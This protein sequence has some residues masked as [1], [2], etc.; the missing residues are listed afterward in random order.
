MQGANGANRSKK[1]DSGLATDPRAFTTA[2]R[3]RTGIDVVDCPVYLIYH[4][5]HQRLRTSAPRVPSASFQHLPTEFQP[6]HSQ[7]EE[8]PRPRRASN[9]PA[10]HS[11]TLRSCTFTT[12]I[13]STTPSNTR[14]RHPRTYGDN[15]PAGINSNVQ[16]LGLPNVNKPDVF[17]TRGAY[18]R[19]SPSIM[20]LHSFH[21]LISHLER[22]LVAL[23]QKDVQNKEVAEQFH[24]HHGFVIAV[25]PYA[26]NANTEQV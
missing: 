4:Q 10:V 21:K 13:S 14:K 26:P 3:G 7:P 15:F 25:A 16:I 1:T 23:L 11:G 19:P 17:H 2:S 12:T 6:H 22:R 20:Q 24:L 5:R 9:F 18:A 8:R